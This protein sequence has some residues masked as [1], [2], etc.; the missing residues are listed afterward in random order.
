M[1]PLSNEYKASLEAALVQYEGHLEEA[2]EYLTGRGIAHGTA[3]RMRLGVAIAPASGH[4]QWAGRLVIPSLGWD[5]RPYALKARCMEQHDCREF[6]HPKYLG[7]SQEARLFNVRAI[8]RAQDTISVTEGELD[9]ITLEQCGYP[10]VG[11]PGASGWRP[12]HARM[13][14]G[15]RTVYV[16][17]DGDHAGR[18]FAR[19]VLDTLPSATVVNMAEGMDVNGLYVEGGQAAIDELLGE[20]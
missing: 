2:R 5:S 7:L 19:E 8:H 10:A 14:A 18:D 1:L 20:T 3:V 4:E 13:L 15:F 11:V 9:A 16:I 12:R 6:K 17:G